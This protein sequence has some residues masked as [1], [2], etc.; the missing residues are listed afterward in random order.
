MRNPI[1][2][3]RKLLEHYDCSNKQMLL[4]L[5]LQDHEVVLDVWPFE[6]SIL[7]VFWTTPSNTKTIAINS[8][9]SP[10]RQTFAIA[11]GIGHYLLEHGN[12][13]CSIDTLDSENKQEQ[14]SNIFAAELLMPEETI[15]KMIG[16][17][18]HD[19]LVGMLGISKKLLLW[20]LKLLDI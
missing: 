3:A 13:L 8:N 2:E 11:H 5:I 4:E 9:H 16:I 10:I 15:K 17:Y 6:E 12:C 18:S 19:Q 20:R 7:G 14:E 1:E